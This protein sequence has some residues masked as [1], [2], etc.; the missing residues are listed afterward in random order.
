MSNARATPLHFGILI[1]QIYRW[2]EYIQHVRYAEA[3][4]F[5]CLW[6]ADHFVN[7]FMPSGDWLEAYTLLGAVAAATS[8]IRLGTL[9]THPMFRH[10]SVITRQ[11]LALDHISGG[12]AEIGIGAGGAKLDY[13]M[14]GVSPRG[15]GELTD[16][17]IEAVEL[18]DGLLRH[19]VFSYQGRY[20]SAEEATM[21]PR[22]VQ[23]PRPP[24]TIAAHGPRT[25]R[26]A[27]ERADTWNFL[28]LSPD[29]TP[30][31]NLATARRRNEMID[32]FATRAG[33]DP[34]AIDRSFALGYTLDRP[35]ASLDAFQDFVG[36]YREAG[37]NEFILGYIPGT[38]EQ[39]I[40]QRFHERWIMDPEQLARVAE[41]I[42]VM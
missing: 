4:G 2:D 17:L 3:L 8:T 35:L 7:P 5:E 12:R 15:A 25:L 42:K 30:D 36:R 31:E 37:I 20:Y 32:E 34:A 11:F 6:L 24:L 33:R 10:P 39:P 27:A 26:L 29:A 41:V 23:Q 28:R 38:A 21:L 40:G 16:R 1:P 13:Q 14:L 22:P 19:E 9:V 18:I